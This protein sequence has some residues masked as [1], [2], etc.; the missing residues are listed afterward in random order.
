MT[1][2]RRTFATLYFVGMTAGLAA[3][4]MLPWWISGA[5]AWALAWAVHDVAESHLPR[6]DQFVTGSPQR[7]AAAWARDRI[8]RSAVVGAF[9]GALSGALAADLPELYARI[10]LASRPLDG[11]DCGAM[12]CAL[13][14]SDAW[15]RGDAPARLSPGARGL[16]AYVTFLVV[17][18]LPAIVEFATR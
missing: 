4:V 1:N 8:A 6:A 11:H 3:G 10:G 14:L 7:I 13:V 2:P 15:V 18:A 16:L 17:V 9:I 5:P 12:A